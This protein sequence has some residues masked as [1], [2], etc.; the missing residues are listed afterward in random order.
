M[1]WDRL[2]VAFED[3]YVKGLR[4]KQDDTAKGVHQMFLFGAGAIAI[5][6]L[7][8]RAGFQGWVK[9][10]MWAASF[11]LFYL[12]LRGVAVIEASHRWKEANE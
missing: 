11:L 2:P 9:W 10:A 6:G 3:R 4:V 1:D 8:P 12:S 5:W 7:M